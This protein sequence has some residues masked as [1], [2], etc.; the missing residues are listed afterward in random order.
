PRQRPRHSRDRGLRRTGSSQGSDWLAGTRA[1]AVGAHVPRY[2]RWA[3]RVSLASRRRAI[4]A[5]TRLSG[6]RRR[7][8]LVHR[9]LRRAQDLVSLSNYET[10]RTRRG[11]AWKENLCALRASASRP[12]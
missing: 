5:R 12:I 9:V 3:A 1:A 10:R 6:L 8:W 2:A 7:I 4:L 11:R